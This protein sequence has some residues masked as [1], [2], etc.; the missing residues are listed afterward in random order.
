[1]RRQGRTQSRFQS[2]LALLVAA[3]VLVFPQ[4]EPLAAEQSD[5]VASIISESEDI[6][7]YRLLILYDPNSSLQ[8]SAPVPVGYQRILA[9]SVSGFGVWMRNFP[10]RSKNEPL[11]RYD[12][13]FLAAPNVIAGV[14][15]LPTNSPAQ[16]A[17]G[18][19]YSFMMEYSRHVELEL[20][21]NFRG[22]ENDTA[23]FYRYLTGS[24]S[25]NAA[26]TRLFWQEGDEKPL[27]ETMRTRFTG[28]ARSV[29]SYN[30]LIRDCQEIPESEV[31]PGDIFVQVDPKDR[32]NSHLIII[33]DVAVRDSSQASLI[34]VFGGG[35]TAERL[36]LLGNSLTPGTNFHVIR[37]PKAGKGKWFVAGEIQDKMR[38]YP[39]GSFYRLPY[40]FL[41]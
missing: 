32:L 2:I 25:T 35:K 8:K 39:D 31:M 16:D 41:R 30:S 23:S 19:L 24:Y 11:T 22:L 5:S 12:G 27:D 37:P 17:R 6:D 38:A 36:F 15:D 4:S 18:C 21:L 10:L 1:M 40:E 26:R 14:L 29:T 20:E 7:P 9:E 28:F 34:S 13:S 33:L 3:M